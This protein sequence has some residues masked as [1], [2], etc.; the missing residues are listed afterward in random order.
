MTTRQFKLEDETTYL[1]AA[2]YVIGRRKGDRRSST[3][4]VG[5]RLVRTPDGDFA[6]AEAL[7]EQL[8]AG[9]KISANPGPFV[10]GTY[11]LP[12]APDPAPAPASLPS[13]AFLV[14]VTVV[15]V[16]LVAVLLVASELRR[17]APLA[18]APLLPP[19]AATAVSAP[20]VAPATAEP[21]P[22]PTREPWT[23][24]IIG[25]PLVVIVRDCFPLECGGVASCHDTVAAL[26]AAFAAGPNCHTQYGW[27][28]A[29]QF[30]WR[31]TH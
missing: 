20:V 28:A 9:A 10:P 23:P 26:D 12:P 15:L 16:A 14:R 30:E 1:A 22:P 31:R 24:I 27:P 17:P 19:S 21:A 29:R 11:P 6:P 3:V 2:D 5:S 7:A 25:P 4:P 18:S 13:P 8:R